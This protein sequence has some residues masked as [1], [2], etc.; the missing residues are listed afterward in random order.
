M[1]HTEFLQEVPKPHPCPDHRYGNAR[2]GGLELTKSAL[3]LR[4]GL[5]VILVSGYTDRAID[6]DADSIG[7]KFLQKPFSLDS[8][9][10]TVR[11][12]LSKNRRILLIDDSQFMR[13][14]IE[15]VLSAAGYMVKTAGDGEEGL[16]LASET[17]PD[18]VLLDVTL[19]KASGAE[20]L[21]RLK[22]DPATREI[23][24]VVLTALSEKN[25]K[26]LLAGGAAAFI[27]KSDKLLEEDA[28]ALINVIGEV[29][30][31]AV[32]EDK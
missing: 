9:A 12:L 21:R 20:V 30:A 18:V 28:A 14:A 15:R 22:N 8:M 5:A 24:V 4:P 27:E 25:K 26:R 7:A 29:L 19:P 6:S 17:R 11:S 3:E 32:G 10:R 2:D 31:K 16:R 1:D 23:P 13:V